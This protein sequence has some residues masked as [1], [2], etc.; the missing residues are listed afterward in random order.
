MTKAQVSLLVIFASRPDFR[1]RAQRRDGFSRSPRLRTRPFEAAQHLHQQLV[2]MSKRGA[3]AFPFRTNPSRARRSRRRAR[4]PRARGARHD[5]RE[6]L[7]SDAR[8]PRRPAERA[9]PARRSDAET[10]ARRRDHSMHRSGVAHGVRGASASSRARR[11]RA[12]L[13]SLASPASGFSA[14]DAMR[15]R[16]AT[17]RTAAATANDTPTRAITRPT[18]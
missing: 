14:L 9:S 6:K 3:Y 17:A 2:K 7:A 16:A 18:S 11:R 1:L 10:L 5:R 4:V 12:S 13:A 8:M 15:S